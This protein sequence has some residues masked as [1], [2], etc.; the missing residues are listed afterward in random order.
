[1]DDS[2]IC[3]LGIDLCLLV[4][5]F[6]LFSVPYKSIKRNE[7]WSSDEKRRVW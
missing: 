6:K 3:N 4:S 5:L 2:R 1:M 7:D